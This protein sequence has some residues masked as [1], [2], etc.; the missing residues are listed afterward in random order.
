MKR[1]TIACVVILFSCPLGTALEATPI[2]YQ[3]S[4]DGAQTIPPTGSLATGLG[5]ITVDS[6]DALTG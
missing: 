2:T 4:L 1:H 3:A 6:A 5:T